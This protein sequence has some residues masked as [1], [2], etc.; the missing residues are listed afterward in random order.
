MNRSWLRFRSHPLIALFC[1][2]RLAAEVGHGAATIAAANRL[3]RSYGSTVF[4]KLVLPC[5]VFAH[6]HGGS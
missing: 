2:I 3:G 6:G 4:G 1:L 5:S